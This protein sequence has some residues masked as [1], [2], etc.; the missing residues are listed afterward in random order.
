MTA[1][2]N[3]PIIKITFLKSNLNDWSQILPKRQNEK[4]LLFFFLIR[5]LL[6]T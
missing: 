2:N 4:K 3:A 5:I 1:P 6:F